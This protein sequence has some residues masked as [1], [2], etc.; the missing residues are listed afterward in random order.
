MWDK[1]IGAVIGAVGT[2]LTAG[3]IACIMQGGM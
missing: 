1:F 3:V 2:A